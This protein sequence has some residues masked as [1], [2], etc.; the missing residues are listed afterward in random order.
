[1]I[2]VPGFACSC[3]YR[4]QI[5][6][7]AAE[8]LGTM[9]LTLLGCAGNCQVVLS[10]NTGVAPSPKGEYL[11]Q[12][13]AWACSQYR[14]CSSTVVPLNRIVDTGISLGAWVASGVTGGH[15]NPVVR[16]TFLG[17]V[18]LLQLR[19]RAQVTVSFAVFR[20]FPWRKVP[21]YVLGQ[22]I[23]AWVGAI[24]VFGNYFHAI[25]IVEGGKGRRTLKTASLFATYA[26][27]DTYT[28]PRVSHLTRCTARLHAFSKLLL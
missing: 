14:F 4:E 20:G 7:P 5:R 15:V 28:C 9:I 21:G 23:G 18:V 13:I 25:D 17:P 11:S 19:I 27:S 1:M 2:I 8:M 6:E 24:V 22:L 26:V 10:A 12:V 3:T 16:F